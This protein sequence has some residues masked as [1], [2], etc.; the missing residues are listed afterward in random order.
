MLTCWTII[1]AITIKSDCEGRLW[2][3]HNTHEN[4]WLGA[5]VKGNTD[6]SSLKHKKDPFK[7]IHQRRKHDKNTWC[8]AAGQSLLPFRAK[9]EIAQYDQMRL[10]NSKFDYQRAKPKTVTQCSLERARCHLRPPWRQM[11]QS[12]TPW[13]YSIMNTSL[14]FGSFWNTCPE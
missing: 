4:G 12:L 6:E 5:V 2:M 3:K 11:T 13:D 7:C 1:V 9:G 8:S 10:G 14:N